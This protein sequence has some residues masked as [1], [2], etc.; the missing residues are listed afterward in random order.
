ME[1]KKKTNPLTPYSLTP[2]QK[3]II[4]SEILILVVSSPVV[5]ESFTPMPIATYLHVQ[6]ITLWSLSSFFT[7][8]ML[9]FFPIILVKILQYTN[10][11]NQFHVYTFFIYI[12]THTHTISL[13]LQTEIFTNKQDIFWI[14]FKN[15]IFKMMLNKRLIH[16]HSV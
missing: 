10:K 9:V 5:L 6:C 3:I 12:Y 15:W 16:E 7:R 14:L 8:G 1:Q 4:T 2:L 13:V 11:W